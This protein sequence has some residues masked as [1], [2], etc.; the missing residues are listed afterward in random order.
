MKE[1]YESL[2]QRGDYAQIRELVE[3]LAYVDEEA[4]EGETSSY[5][6]TM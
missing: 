3:Q 4:N 2:V 6:G 5:L 1:V